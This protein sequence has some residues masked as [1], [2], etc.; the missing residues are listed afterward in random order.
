MVESNHK[1]LFYGKSN[2]ERWAISRGQSP[3]T[4][5]LPQQTEEPQCMPTTAFNKNHTNQST[6]FIENKTNT[7][8]YGHVLDFTLLKLQNNA[9]K[10]TTIYTTEQKSSGRN[11]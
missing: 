11:Y 1:A 10:T 8:I 7:L 3:G 9:L 5:L 6:V 2:R 4:T